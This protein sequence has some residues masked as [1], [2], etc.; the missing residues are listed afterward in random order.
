MKRLDSTKFEREERTEEMK[1]G[2]EFICQF[3]IKCHKTKAVPP[4]G[5]N[6]IK[7]IRKIPLFFF[8]S[9]TN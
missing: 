8:Y 4:K 6:P 5:I 7:V 9:Q 3:R 2:E 1:K